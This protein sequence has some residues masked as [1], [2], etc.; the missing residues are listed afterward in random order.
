[1]PPETQTGENTVGCLVNGKVFLPHRKGIYPAVAIFY[2]FVGGEFFFSL[3]FDNQRGAGLKGVTIG[4]LRVSFQE[5]QPY[6]LNKNNE[7]DG[8]FTGGGGLYTINTKIYYYT[9]STS[10]G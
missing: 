6:I 8:D 1:M 5:G 2:E 9:N 4:T 7:V 10:T 3:S